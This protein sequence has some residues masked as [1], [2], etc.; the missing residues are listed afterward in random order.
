MRYSIILCALCICL[1]LPFA[2]SAQDSSQ[3]TS[4]YSGSFGGGLAL[5]GGNTDTK[6]FNLSLAVVRDPKTRNLVKFDALYLRGSQSNVL[7]LDKTSVVLRDEYTFSPKAFVFAQTD[8]LR[9]Q[10]K[11]INYLIAPV[12]G[13]GFK[14]ANT[15][16]RKLT[17][18]AGLGGIWEKNPGQV[19]RKSG[20]V[21]AGQNFSQKIST[22]ATFTQSIATNWKT[23]DFSD[24][25]TNF[26]MALTTSV[27]GK[28]EVKT[29]F[30]DSYKNRPATPGIK[31]NDT[32]FVTSFV[33]KF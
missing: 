5:T 13:A 24:S 9:D 32:A 10:F 29:E 12:A 25:L 6:N 26:S 18:S 20:S 22:S 30:I 16:D 11:A 33:I 19:V 1:I 15:D 23:N 17:V 27:M 28:L 8:Y 7:S 4:V 14:F 21:N 2:A 3:P 31:K